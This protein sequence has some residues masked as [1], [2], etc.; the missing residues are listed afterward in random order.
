MRAVDA[1][2][3]ANLELARVLRERRL[4]GR[5]AAFATE[6]TYGATR[7]RGRY[8]PIISLAAGRP[9]EVIDAPVLDSLRLGVH[10]L[11]GMRVPTHA[12]TAETVALARQVHG[13]GA[14]GFVNAVLRRVGERDGESW[15]A[16]VAPASL[17]PLERLAIVHSHPLWVVTALRA[18]LIG[19]GQ[20]TADTVQAELAA[21]LDSDNT[22]PLVTLVA[23][24]GLA[25]VAELVAAG[26]STGRLSPTSAVL[27]QG[28]PGSL[29]AIREGRAGVQDEGSQLVALALVAADV[30]G[31][32]PE[33]WLDLC[34][35]PGGKAG[36]LAAVAR[37]RAARFVA[38]D[39]SPH[40]SE[41]VRATLATII[42]GAAAG[43]VEVRTMDGREVGQL[44]PGGYDRVLVDA[45]CTGLGAL[46]RRPEARWRRSPG[47]LPTLSRLQRELLGSA[48]DATR[49][50][51]IVGYATCSPHLSETR[52]AVED[53]VRRRGD[54]EVVDARGLFRD[55]TGAPLPDLGAGPFVQL[56]PHVHATDGMFFALIRKGG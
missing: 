49:A 4:H 38:N 30:R 3:Y 1:G 56:W 31:D 50:G 43:A 44:E 46:R 39:V 25:E 42:H 12:A 8:D 52:Y 41:L 10:Q 6:L 18:A 45:P 14:A 20:A 36:L 35:G 7:L 26:A 47:D 27:P 34:A 23:R 32:G 48:L 55:R 40:R 54:V 51:G 37:Q 17:P 2:A 19:H 11:L 22:A 28:D 9:L 21:L 13:I 29:A 53:A 24:P 33:H 5:D 15:L 16:A